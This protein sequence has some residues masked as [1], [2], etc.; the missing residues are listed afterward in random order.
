MAK[1]IILFSLMCLCSL[2]P[3]WAQPQKS[4]KSVKE[5]TTRILSKK[6]AKRFKFKIRPS[7]C[8][9]FEISAS[10]K[11]IKIEA[12]TP[13]AM[14][15]GLNYYFTHEM[16]LATGWNNLRPNIPPTALRP[17]GIRIRKESPYATVS[18]FTQE[19]FNHITA[20]WNWERWEQEIDLMALH[21]V[22]HPFTTNMIETLPDLLSHKIARR[23]REYGM[24]LVEEGA[25]SDSSQSIC[26]MPET[27]PDNP[28]IFSMR[29]DLVWQHEN[30]DMD[31]WM[32]I[33]PT[34]RYGGVSATSLQTAWEGFHKTAFNPQKPTSPPL[35]S[36]FYN[37]P[38]LDITTCLSCWLERNIPYDHNLFAASCETFFR[39]ADSLRFNLNY[40][41]DA[42]NIVH[43]YLTNLGY[44]AY[45]NLTQAKNQHD[46]QI[47]D[48]ETKHFLRLMDDHRSLLT[49]HPDP[50]EVAESL[51]QKYRAN[52]LAPDVVTIELPIS[53]RDGYGP[54]KPVFYI[55]QSFSNHQDLWNQTHILASGV[56]ARWSEIKRGVIKIDPNTHIAFATGKDHAGKIEMVV[57]TNNNRDFRDDAVF[58]PVEFAYTL[59]DYELAPTNQIIPLLYER[60]SG[61]HNP[62]PFCVGKM[63]GQDIIM[64]SFA[65]HAT[66]HLREV[67]LAIYP[68]A[69]SNFS[70]QHT[71][72]KVINDPR[73]TEKNRMAH[74]SLD[75]Y[76]L[77]HDT[78]FRHKG[79]DLDRR[80]LLLDK[81]TVSQNQLYAP[82]VGFNAIP[83]KGENYINSQIISPS[84][85]FSGKYL[86]LYFWGT[87][88]HPCTQ[89]LPRLRTMYD[90]WDRS[91]VEMVGIIDNSPTISLGKLIQQYHIT[92]PQILSTERNPIVQDYKISSFPTILLIA[93]NGKIVAKT[94]N[95]DEIERALDGLL[96]ERP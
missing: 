47:F 11:K 56:P 18:Y 7:A 23:I 4:S 43:K 51:F 87:W 13:V 94:D 95:W 29:S 19:H 67:E 54:F 26:L 42:V 60:L 20:S 89:E 30:L 12:N 37:Q 16:L 74:I 10:G 86:V 57:D 82:Q 27:I 46:N 41:S 88:C 44:K 66:A 55:L 69:F 93:P 34:Y 65:R 79:I 84:E 85:D 62:I 32:K 39:F 92:W 61:F 77:L 38:S 91:M 90:K 28:I 6:Q 96:Y 31:G 21:G 17:P 8:N 36:I 75:D 3:L 35:E 22:T 52:E 70:F 2:S 72:L 59:P 68:D 33:F 78:L 1:R 50:V 24:T 64:G 9:F 83:F 14:A 80:V 63:P 49:I 5:L 81:T 71:E 53:F 58:T 48:R 45:Y 73:S 40:Q 25:A 76:I 15:A